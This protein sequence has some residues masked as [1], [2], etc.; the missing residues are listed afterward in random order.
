MLLIMGIAR[1]RAALACAA[2]T[3]ARPNARAS[4]SLRSETRR[5]RLMTVALWI[6]VDLV[7]ALSIYL[8]LTNFLRESEMTTILLPTWPHTSDAAFFAAAK[9]VF[10]AFRGYGLPIAG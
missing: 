7:F 3:S 8:L 5:E 6:I 2:S 1:R 10:D 9:E 4:F